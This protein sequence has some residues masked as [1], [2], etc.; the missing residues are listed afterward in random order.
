[1]TVVEFTLADLS[2][3]RFVSRYAVKLQDKA[4]M[5]AFL[6]QLV[7]ELGHAPQTKI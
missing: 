5:K 2:N 1:V 4:A 6:Q 3:Q 7:K